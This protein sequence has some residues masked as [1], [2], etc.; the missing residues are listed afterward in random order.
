M[1]CL[2]TADGHLV[3]N[4]GNKQKRVDNVEHFAPNMYDKMKFLAS[5][6]STSATTRHS[7]SLDHSEI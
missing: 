3:C 5:V 4:S 6:S 2:Y 7:K 1:N